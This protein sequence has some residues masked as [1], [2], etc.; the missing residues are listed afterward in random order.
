MVGMEY[1]LREAAPVANADLVAL[2][3]IHRVE[4]SDSRLSRRLRAAENL[5]WPRPSARADCGCPREVDFLCVLSRP[6]SVGTRTANK[7]SPFVHGA[8]RANNVSRSTG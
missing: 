3:T 2:Q 1:G 5:R 6:V 7:H 4:E 8:Q